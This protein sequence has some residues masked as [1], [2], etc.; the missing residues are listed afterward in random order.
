MPSVR[1]EN[2]HPTF[3]SSSTFLEIVAGLHPLSEFNKHLIVRKKRL[4]SSP[5]LIGADPEFFIGNDKKLIPSCGLIGGDKGAGVPIPGTSNSKWLEDNVA[6]EINVPPAESG[7]QFANTIRDAIGNASSALGK[8]KLHPI[9]KPAL[10]FRTEDLIHP[11]ASRF[12]CDPDFCAYDT[13]QKAPRACDVNKFQNTRFAGGHVHL[14]F[15]NRD[16]IPA[17][18]IAMLMDA[19]IGL[20][21]LYYDKQDQRRGAYGL[22]GLYRTKKYSDDIEG[23]E[24]RSLSNFWLPLAAGGSAQLNVVTCLGDTLLSIGRAIQE[25]PS[26]LSKLFIRLPL[27]DIQEAINKED[28]DRG[29]EIWNFIRNTEEMSKCVIDTSFRS[30][31]LKAA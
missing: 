18:A 22:A 6:V 1:D 25:Y 11:K 10:T 21:S 5:I 26:E 20:P 7:D 16:K 28:H 30:G 27:R 24:Y 9:F 17:Y 23:I 14:S 2:G 31:L 13:D 29:Y 12:G 4:S 8:M 19:F 15:N 3:V